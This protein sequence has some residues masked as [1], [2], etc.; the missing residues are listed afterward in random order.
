M[1][2]RKQP[3]TRKRATKRA[4]RPTP[5]TGDPLRELW[6][7]GLGAV[8]ATGETAAEAFDTLVARGRRLEPTVVA[9]AERTAREA[10]GA[11]EELAAEASRRSKKLVDEALDRIGAHRA[12]RSKN[13][14]HRLGD[15]AEALL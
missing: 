5:P 4:A 12:P 8:A 6:L 14:L 13:I 7:A 2:A 9:A 10:R 1:T 11:V 3:K 15:I